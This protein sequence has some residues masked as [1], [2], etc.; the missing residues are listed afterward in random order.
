MIKTAS[1]LR[2]LQGDNPNVVNKQFNINAHPQFAKT[3]MVLKAVITKSGKEG[4]NKKCHEI[5]VAAFVEYSFFSEATT[6]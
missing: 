4:V 5:M 3:R 2:S 6:F 1:E